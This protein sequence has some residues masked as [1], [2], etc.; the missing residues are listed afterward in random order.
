MRS[1]GPIQIIEHIRNLG[2]VISPISSALRTGRNIAEVVQERLSMAGLALLADP[3]SHLPAEQRVADAGVVGGLCFRVARR[4]IDLKKLIRQTAEALLNVFTERL[5]G[6]VFRPRRERRCFVRIRTRNQWHIILLSVF[7]NLVYALGQHPA[8]HIGRETRQTGSFRDIFGRLRSQGLN[9]I[10]FHGGGEFRSGPLGLRQRLHRSKCRPAFAYGALKQAFRER[11]RHQVIYAPR[12][13][14]LAEDSHSLRIAAES[15]DILCHP[16][17]RRDLIEQRIV[18]GRIVVRFPGQLRVRQK[19]EYAQPVVD[20][21][22][23]RALLR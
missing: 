5:R 23:D 7:K 10:H 11:S 14:G 17:Q 18:P 22:H 3:G 2:R 9:G 1:S 21:D 12:S 16:M 19:S 15:S 4:W 8:V 13:G 20:R 6:S